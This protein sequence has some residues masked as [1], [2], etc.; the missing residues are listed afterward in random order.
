VSTLLVAIAQFLRVQLT[1]IL[2]IRVLNSWI[3]PKPWVCSERAGYHC[4]VLRILNSD[5]VGEDSTCK[6]FEPVLIDLFQKALRRNP[7]TQR[8]TKPVH[9]HREMCGLPSA[10]CRGMALERATSSKSLGDLVALCCAA[11]GRRNTLQLHH[12]C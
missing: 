11:W 9:K 3:C 2:S 7:D 5:W 1:A 4:G 12:Y 8:V 6:C 10:G